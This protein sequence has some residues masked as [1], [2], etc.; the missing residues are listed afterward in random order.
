MLQLRTFGSVD[1][2]DHEGRDLG[3]VLAQP[4]RLALLVYLAAARPSRIHRRDHLLPLFWPDLDA[5]RTRDALNQSL[6]FLRQAVGADAFVRRGGDEVGLDPEQV[7][8]D[9]PAFQA[10][11]EAGHPAAVPAPRPA[12]LAGSRLTITVITAIISPCRAAWNPN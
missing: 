2:K 12:G 7:W 5:S 1:L 3:V 9:V 4:K 8:C 10:A 11:L 6:S